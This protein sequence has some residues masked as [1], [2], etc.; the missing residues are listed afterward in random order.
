M[1]GARRSWGLPQEAEGPGRAQQ[2]TMGW[3]GRTLTQGL[4]GPGRTVA[5]DLGCGKGGG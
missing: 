2:V 5:G 3:V 4:R 1:S